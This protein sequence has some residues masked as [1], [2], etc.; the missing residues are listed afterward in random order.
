MLKLSSKKFKNNRENLYVII[1]NNSKAL[2]YASFNIKIDLDYILLFFHYPNV[3]TTS[4][5]EIGEKHNEL[6]LSESYRIK[7]S[8][9]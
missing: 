1:N 6:I 5:L 8:K 3:M 2:K 7:K 4:P 9:E